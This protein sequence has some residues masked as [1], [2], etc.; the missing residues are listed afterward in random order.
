MME[1]VAAFVCQF[2]IVPSVVLPV[3][4]LMVDGYAVVE[5]AMSAVPEGHIRL[6]RHKR[7]AAE[8]ARQLLG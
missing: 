7:G 1:D 3:F 8:V 4:V 6:Y 2:E 5:F